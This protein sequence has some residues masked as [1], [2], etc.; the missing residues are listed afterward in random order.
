[1][2]ARCLRFHYLLSSN[3]ISDNLVRLPKRSFD[4]LCFVWYQRHKTEC[5]RGFSSVYI[6]WDSYVSLCIYDCLFHICWLEVSLSFFRCLPFLKKFTSMKFCTFL[7]LVNQFLTV[8]HSFFLVD[9]VAGT[10]ATKSRT[11]FYKLELK[12][13]YWNL[14][15]SRLSDF[16]SFMI[17]GH[18][19]WSFFISYIIVQLVDVLSPHL[20]TLHQLCCIILSKQWLTC[21][22]SHLKKYVLWPLFPWDQNQRKFWPNFNFFSLTHLL[23]SLNRINTS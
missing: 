23:L 21:Q 19:L 11:I 10:A 6:V 1:M 17:S 20:Q 7:F 22:L 5:Q 9:R 13:T 2:L 4:I 14:C 15:F 18:F 3:S 12:L 16:D 8:C